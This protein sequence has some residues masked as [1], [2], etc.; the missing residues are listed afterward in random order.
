MS[1]APAFH[2]K[3]RRMGRGA[4]GAT[5]CRGVAGEGGVALILVLWLIVVMAA[6]AATMVAV[7][8][9][10]TTVVVNARA[11][12]AARYAAESGLVE[13]KALLEQ[14][15]AGAYTPEGQI[16]A[17]HDLPRVL[18][19]LRE[20]ALGGARFGVIGANLS[21]RLDLNL[22][23][24]AALTGL[25]SQFVPSAAAGALTDA[26]LDWRDADELTRPLGAEADAYGRAGS[27]FVPRNGPLM[28]PDELRRVRGVT[29]SLAVALAP[30]V[31]VDGDTL[32]D[33]NAAPETVLAALPSVGPAGARVIV[34]R[35]RQGEIF[36]S[37]SEVLS[38]LGQLDGATAP[39][40]TRVT[41][42]PTR[43]L[44]IS[45]GWMAGHPL[46][47]EIQAA[48]GVVGQRLLLRSWR[49]RDL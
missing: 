35:R 14:R 16:L 2:R 37:A 28:H 49:E 39:P 19:G 15:L 43:V 12:V 8:R 33:I 9:N 6:I 21:A 25:F 22:A 32:V 41:V 29:D 13:G 3:R 38:L 34:S 11:R 44:L 10:E 40:I 26:L 24:P 20:V 47:H 7:S 48:Y 27:M 1:H 42:V 18:A 4:I 36:A 30:Y 45:R 5:A 23:E 31:T 46:I 17:L